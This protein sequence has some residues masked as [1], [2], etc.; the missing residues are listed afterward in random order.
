MGGVEP[1]VEEEEKLEMSTM[2]LLDSMLERMKLKD[3]RFEE[4][5]TLE[6]FLI[7]G[8]MGIPI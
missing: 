7:Y 3:E 8:E 5:M 1:R 2:M 6:M 4:M